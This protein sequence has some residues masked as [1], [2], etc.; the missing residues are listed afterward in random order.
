M[1]FW[2]KSVHPFS[3][4]L[5][6]PPRENAL[7]FLEKVGW[8]VLNLVDQERKKSAKRFRNSPEEGWCVWMDVLRA[9]KTASS[10]V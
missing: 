10:F 3:F 4:P 8:R 2:C 1:L 5:S 9:K 6:T 7:A